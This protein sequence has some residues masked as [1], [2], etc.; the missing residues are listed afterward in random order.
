VK[1]LN[2]YPY[3]EGY[4]SSGNKTTTIRLRRPNC[5]DGEMVQLT[6]GWSESDARRLHNAQII[7]VY[8]KKIS[9][10]CQIDFDGESPDCKE[11]ETTALVLSA[12]YRT[13]VRLDDT[14]WVVKFK[15]LVS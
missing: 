6:L 12:I 15:H 1:T 13:I 4:L 3:Y 9:S 11:P 5:A 8:P 7:S 14:V 2:F 10:L